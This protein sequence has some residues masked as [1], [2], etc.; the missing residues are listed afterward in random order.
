MF[1]NKYKSLALI[2]VEQYHGRFCSGIYK[3]KYMIHKFS[4]SFWII[5]Y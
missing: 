3:Q 2:F 4:G 5:Q 1:C